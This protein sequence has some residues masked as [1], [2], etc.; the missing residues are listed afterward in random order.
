MFQDNKDSQNIGSSISKVAKNLQSS[1]KKK[2]VTTTTT[3][4]FM[5][6]KRLAPFMHPKQGRKHCP[7]SP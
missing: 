7:P 4:M 5:P 6:T 1:K 2:M 3:N